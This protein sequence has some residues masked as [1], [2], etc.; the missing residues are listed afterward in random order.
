MVHRVCW[1]QVTEVAVRVNRVYCKEL[2]DSSSY[3][4][5][6]VLDGTD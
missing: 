2:I 4:A 5:S 3:G 1:M 6:C